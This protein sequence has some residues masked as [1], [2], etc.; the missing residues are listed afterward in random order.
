MERKDLLPI[1]S[2]VM[3]EN[4]KKPVMIYGRFQREV[5]T[6]KLWDYISC[7]Y[8]EG[9]VNQEFTFLFNHENIKDVLF[10]GMDSDNDKAYVDAVY[11]RLGEAIEQ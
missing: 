3:L 5:G 1:G 6:G 9:N 11:K 7:L 2:V 10:R 8:P 4:G